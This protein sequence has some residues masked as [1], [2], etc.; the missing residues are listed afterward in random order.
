MSRSKKPV[1]MV[2]L[3]LAGLMGLPLVIWVVS[4]AG[5]AK[6]VFQ[7]EEGGANGVSSGS[8]VVDFALSQLEERAEELISGAMTEAV[9]KGDMPIDFLGDLKKEVYRARSDVRS[10]KLD[11]AK[12]RYRAVVSAAEE[13]LAA[14]VAADKARALNDSIKA[15]LQRLQDLRASFQNTYAEAVASYNDA[16]RLLEAGDFVQSVEQFEH[17]GAILGDLEARSMQQT[18]NMLE[19]A[20]DALDKYEL[21]AAREAFQAVLEADPTNTAGAEGVAMVDAL[22]GNADAVEAVR[23]LEAEGKLEEALARLDTLAEEHPDNPFIQK[24]ASSLEKRLLDRNF[25]HLIE[26][27]MAAEAAGDL[28]AAI[29]GLEA[30][31]ELKAD[32]EQRTRLEKLKTAQRAT[33]LEAVLEKGFQALKAARYEAARDLYKEAVALDPNSKEARTGLERASSLYLAN[34]RY[35]QNV[36]SAARYIDDGR[37]PLAARLFNLAMTSRPENLA[38]AQVK[39]E[40]AIRDSLEAQSKEVLVT[41]QSDGRTFVSIIGVQAPERF[42]TKDLKLFPD[43]YKARGTRRG[44][45]DVEIEFNVDATK[46]SHRITVQCIEKL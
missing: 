38:P 25:K 39:K 37:F 6:A 1:I 36:A 33:R 27:S 30:A 11:R 22:E 16:L 34:I 23:A 7:S 26:R 10:G 28:A 41:V 12:E 17:A 19:V 46:E 9:R 18:V 13:R 32:T 35:S 40:E 44:Y 24:Q 3:F 31:L 2:A 14:L 45:K 4:N 42:S 15:E 21:T 5:G 20:Q 8:D 29:T 43:V